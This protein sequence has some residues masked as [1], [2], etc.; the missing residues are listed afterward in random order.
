MISF[1]LLLLIN[2]SKRNSFL[3]A[4]FLGCFVAG[5][6]INKIGRK[7]TLLTTS[8]LYLLGYSSVILGNI[9][10]FGNLYFWFGTIFGGF[11]VSMT[12]HAVPV[13]IVEV[14][15]ARLR[16]IMGSIPY[17]AIIFGIFLC[18]LTKENFY[19]KIGKYYAVP[20]LIVVLLSLL[21]IYMPETPWWLLAHNQKEKA[22]KNML[23]ILG[24][25][26]DAE[27][28]CNQI[29]INLAH[30]HIASVNDFRTPGLYRPLL[31]G[32]FLVFTHQ[33]SFVGCVYAVNNYE[34]NYNGFIKQLFIIQFEVALVGCFIVN[35]CS[36][37][38]LLLSG[39]AILCLCSVG[40]L[41]LCILKICDF[42]DEGK[43][44][45][46]WTINLSIYVTVFSTTWG[47]LPWIIIS[48]VIPPRAS[49]LLGSLVGLVNWLL[50]FLVSNISSFNLD[51]YGRL[52]FFCFTA[53][54]LILSFIFVYYIV[55]E[56]KKLTL[57]EIEHYY[58]INR[59]FRNYLS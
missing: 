46:I 7:S 25:E 47:P 33:F 24:N 19:S 49:G 20:G 54:L 52:V 1:F 16:S 35:L 8:V 32:C 4:A 50:L 23:W 22:F 57:E 18:L 28:A 58:I 40:F 41:L 55:P 53:N 9:E 42:I 56:T 6:L 39:S 11:A 21:I 29:E 45:K 30:R 2:S 3:V 17:Y 36:R 59:G 34:N 43:D 48:E 10:A 27:D 13:Y 26:C 5:I 31:I 37:R 12:F 44:E 15:S 38:F 14:S 51:C